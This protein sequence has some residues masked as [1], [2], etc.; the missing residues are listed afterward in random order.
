MRSTDDPNSGT[1]QLSEAKHCRS[2]C[3]HTLPREAALWNSGTRMPSAHVL[4]KQRHRSHPYAGAGPSCECRDT[5]PT[6]SSASCMVAQCQLQQCTMMFPTH[7]IPAWRP[8]RTRPTWLTTSSSMLVLADIS[9]FP[10]AAGPGAGGDC[11]SRA[12]RKAGRRAQNPA[13]AGHSAVCSRQ[14]GNSRSHLCAFFA[15]GV[16][17]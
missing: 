3:C 8:P 17:V 1:G 5:P 14:V 6:A 16:Q 11:G 13:G 4:P 2:S 10:M 9:T 15:R 7:L 12:R